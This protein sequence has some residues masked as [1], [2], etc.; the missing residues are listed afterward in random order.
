MAVASMHLGVWSWSRKSPELQ[1]ECHN[2]NESWFK[3]FWAWHGCWLLV[4]HNLLSY[5]D[6]HAQ[7]FL[8]FKK[9]SVKREKHQECG[10]PVGENALLMLKVRRQCWLIQA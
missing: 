3:Q 9:N 7:P 10:S 6:F 4:F 5:W 1:T 8:G 2:G